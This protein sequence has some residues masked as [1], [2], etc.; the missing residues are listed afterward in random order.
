MCHIFV[1]GYG[2]VVCLYSERRRGLQ[3]IWYLV[4]VVSHV[5]VMPRW[6]LRIHAQE[7]LDGVNACL[8][9]TTAIMHASRALRVIVHVLGLAL[10]N[11]CSLIRAT[12]V[13]HA[14]NLLQRCVR[15]GHA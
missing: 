15:A 10:I 8:R 6:W 13:S 5:V 4:T 9:S 2:V 7:L 14:A 1:F 3:V 12:S 11:S